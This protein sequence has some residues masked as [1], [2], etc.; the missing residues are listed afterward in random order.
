MNI[1]NIKK[2]AD[3]YARQHFSKI[4]YIVLFVEIVLLSIQMV[5]N[6]IIAILLGIASVTITHA[7]TV[8]S[9]KI[10][11]DESEKI[12][13]KD[14]VV[15][16]TDFARLFPTYIMRKVSLNILSIAILLPAIVFVRFKTGFALGEFLDWMRMIVVSGVDDLSGIQGVTQYLSNEMMVLSLFVSMV[17]TAMVSYGFAMVP[18]LVEEYDISWYEAMMKSWVMMRG[19]KKELFFLELLYVPRTI[20]AFVTMRIFVNIFA[21]SSFAMILSS[22]ILSIY[23]P[24]FLYLPNMEIASAK[25]YQELISKQKQAELFEL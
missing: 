6:Q 1:R 12:S 20:L 21:F 14:S 10:V 3:Q 4:M 13:F 19:H 11:K 5:S 18:Y 7:Y 15:G 16:I 9:L 23:L 24:L 25:F 17:I 2:V 22:L 8:F